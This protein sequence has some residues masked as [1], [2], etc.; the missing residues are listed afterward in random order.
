VEK[1]SIAIDSG[2]GRVNFGDDDL[3]G[4]DPF[5]VCKAR[6]VDKRFHCGVIIHNIIKF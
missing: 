5:E 6:L 4:I 2:D 1:T 3:P